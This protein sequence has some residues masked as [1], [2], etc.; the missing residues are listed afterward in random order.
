MPLAKKRVQSA[1]S[2]LIGMLLNQQFHLVIFKAMIKNLK[3][4]EDVSCEC[5]KE[6]L[7]GDKLRT[8]LMS[9]KWGKENR[10]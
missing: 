10:S 1:A 9:E 2:Q 8:V 4:C 3:E 6:I 7:K 5:T